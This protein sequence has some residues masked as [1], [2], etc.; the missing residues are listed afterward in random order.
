MKCYLKTQLL[1]YVFQFYFQGIRLGPWPCLTIIEKDVNSSHRAYF[2]CINV[3]SGVCVLLLL[4]VTYVLC[5]NKLALVWTFIRLCLLAFYACWTMAASLLWSKACWCFP[6][7]CK[8]HYIL[9]VISEP[10][11]RA[12]LGKKKNLA[13]YISSTWK[14]K[15]Q[16][17]WSHLEGDV[18][19][20][21]C[22]KV[23]FCCFWGILHALCYFIR[24]WGQ[25]NKSHLFF[26]FLFQTLIFLQHIMIL[27]DL[28]HH[29]L[30]G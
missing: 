27:F 4:D 29:K 18:W 7:Q 23:F 13:E 17:C 22:C 11:G 24:Q 25:L 15:E 1:R 5:L 19:T 21:C 12:D 28:E 10:H 30:L 8:R 20:F 26:I 16:L 3:A 9:W 6:L 2:L 14:A